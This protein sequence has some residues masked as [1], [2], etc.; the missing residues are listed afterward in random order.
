MHCSFQ[1][2]QQ[3]SAGSHSVC[4]FDSGQPGSPEIL[5]APVQLPFGLIGEQP[6]EIDHLLLLT[7]V[8]LSRKSR[9]LTLS[10]TGLRVMTCHLLDQL[11]L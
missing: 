8:L 2:T 10:P 3:L 5:V 1:V 7:D 9:L 11:S 4:R 6:I